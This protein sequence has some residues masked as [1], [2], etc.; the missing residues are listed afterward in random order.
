MFLGTFEPNLMDKG[1]LA[2]PK[3]IRDELDSQRLILTI[4]FEECIFGFN[5][6]NWEEI[7]DT[8]L[9]RPLFS[10]KEGRD[11]R[12]K[13]CASAINL[14]LDSQGRFIIPGEMMSYAR[15]SSSLII[16]GAGDHFEIWNKGK[17][18]EYRLKMTG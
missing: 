11:L 9:N 7:T 2:L 8:E 10:D 3:K 4:G 5:V 15:I 17:W 13:M 16:I 1:R 6:K 12:R 18:E 14:E